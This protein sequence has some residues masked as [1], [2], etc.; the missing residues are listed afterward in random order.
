M[1]SMKRALLA[2]FA[3]SIALPAQA[4]PK[5]DALW[6]RLR[7]RLEKLEQ[8]LDGVGGLSVKDLKTGATIDIRPDE[9]FP[10]ASVIKLAIVYDLYRQAEEGR[11]DLAE[12]TRMPASRVGGGGILQELGP[13]VSLTWR[14]VAVLV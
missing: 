14:D 8:S 2:V 1:E 6:A 3:F 11:I 12:V 9:T 10:Q 13:S 7:T 5:E 4:G